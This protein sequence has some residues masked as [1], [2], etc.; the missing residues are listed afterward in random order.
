MALAK[1]ILVYSIG[2]IQAAAN[3]PTSSTHQGHGLLTTVLQRWCHLTDRRCKFASC[4]FLDRGSVS[5]FVPYM[6]L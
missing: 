3:N 2:L 5:A 6:M 4:T 1:N